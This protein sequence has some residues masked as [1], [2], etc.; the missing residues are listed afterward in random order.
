M[1]AWNKNIE[2]LNTILKSLS[3]WDN[4]PEIVGPD[5]AFSQWKAKTIR[6]R[7][8]KKNVYLI[9]NGASASM[10]SHMAADLANTHGVPTQVFTD[11]SLISAV[12]N[13]FG[14]ENIFSEPLRL[15]MVTGEMLVAIS[16]SGQSPNLLKAAEVAATLGGFVVTI[17][18]MSHDNPL[19][20]LGHLNFYVPA[21]TYG[22]A[23]AAHAAILHYWVDIL[24]M[25]TST[26]TDS[27][28]DIGLN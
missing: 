18:G 24:G 22:Y 28:K 13:D 16:S 19:R 10:A 15:R 12:A 9:G 20:R 11:S 4:A 3:V 5:L 26:K 14:Y 17:T 6:I 7:D 25:D 1:I 23:E 8:R 21:E 2:N 27:G